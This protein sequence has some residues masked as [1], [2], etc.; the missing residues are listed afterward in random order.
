M[1]VAKFIIIGNLPLA[2]IEGILTVIIIQFI[3]KIKPELL[4]FYNN[5]KFS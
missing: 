3:K 5:E 4:H 1:D 2:I